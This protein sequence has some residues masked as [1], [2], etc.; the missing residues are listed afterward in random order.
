MSGRCAHATLRLRLALAR[1]NRMQVSEV[2][3]P[4]SEERGPPTVCLGLSFC[5]CLRRVLIFLGRPEMPDVWIA[6]PDNAWQFRISGCRKCEDPEPPERV[7]PDTT[8][9]EG[10]R[11]RDGPLP[12]VPIQDEEPE[13]R[14]KPGRM[15]T[16]HTGCPLSRLLRNNT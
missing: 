1:L 15:A 5:W 16:I 14:P 4:L 13:P 10:C 9:T 12:L 8:A 3:F 11:R 6:G 7:T 2:R